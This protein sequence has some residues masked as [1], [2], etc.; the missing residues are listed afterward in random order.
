MFAADF[1]EFFSSSCYS[2]LSRAGNVDGPHFPRAHERAMDQ[3][4][5]SLGKGSQKF[6]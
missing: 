5:P 2:A 4:L 3:A 6:T 1:A